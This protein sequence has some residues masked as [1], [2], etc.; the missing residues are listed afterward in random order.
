M[1]AVA[2]V[3]S[4]LNGS[5]LSSLL[6]SI[7][8]QQ[9][10]DLV[11]L[12][13]PDAT[14]SRVPLLVELAGRS[15]GV[16][17]SWERA[18]CH[19]LGRVSRRVARQTQLLRNPLESGRSSPGIEV[20]TSR[21]ARRALAGEVDLILVVGAWIPPELA[22]CIP[23]TL[24]LQVLIGGEP[25]LGI[26]MAGFREVFAGRGRTRV[27]IYQLQ[28]ADLGR[29][30]LVDGHIRTRPFFA[31]NQAN[32]WA[33]TGSLLS[34]CTEG[35]KGRDSEF[36]EAPP[37]ER[38]SGS[39]DA[40][41]L[42]SQV[43]AYPVRQAVRVVRGAA[44]QVSGRRRW[45]IAIHKAGASW[46]VVGEALPVEPPPSGM[47]HADPF[48]Y[49]DPLHD[50]HY[51]FVEEFDRSVGRAHIAV[52]EEQHG[53]WR[54]RGVAL[55]ERHHLSFPF[56]FEYAG[57]L[58]MCPESGESGCVTLYRCTDLPMRWERSSV[59]M[60]G[61]STADTVLF[62]RGGRWWLLTNVDKGRVP[63]HQ[64]ELHVFYADSPLSDRW[65]GLPGN[66]VKVDSCGAR[67][68]GL[69]VVQGRLVRFGQ[70]QSFEAY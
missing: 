50:K 41:T 27:E 54:R 5:Q 36:V 37:R 12:V 68:G 32:L 46:D 8:F 65:T 29:R 26:A 10:F 28:P 6:A 39:Y 47:F 56:V 34:S 31:L 33:R 69:S 48:L 55:R 40:A 22:E 66:P 38:E 61:V 25:E 20:L 45:D 60:R 1:R 13:H 63:D 35:A 43:A 7:R 3:D 52:L 16:L 70:V 17:A 23:Q 14:S 49:W 18:L 67:N 42:L 30:L 19:L 4:R 59:L 24:T 51:C 62:E 2:I 53:E 11:A 57:D 21:E 64:N 15:A 9:S 58:Y 44:R